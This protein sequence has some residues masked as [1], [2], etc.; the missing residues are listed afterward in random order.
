MLLQVKDGM[1]QQKWALPRSRHGLV[2]TDSANLERPRLKL[3]AVFVH[4]LALHLFVIDPRVASDSSMITECAAQ[5]LEHAQLKLAR[6]NKPRAMQLCCFASR[7]L[8]KV[9]L[10][11]AQRFSSSS[12]LAIAG[13]PRL[14]I[15]HVRRKIILA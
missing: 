1:D 2:G 14:T 5:A 12:L 10:G 8:S 15:V 3:H 9:V 11:N 13:S 7:L 6:F 4:G